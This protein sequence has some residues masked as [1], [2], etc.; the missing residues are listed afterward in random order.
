MILMGAFLALLVWGYR[1]DPQGELPLPLFLG[2]AAVPVV[3]ILGVALA[4][5]QRV[6]EIGRGEEDDAGKY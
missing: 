5:G 3:V 6:Q 4:L 2:I 1:T